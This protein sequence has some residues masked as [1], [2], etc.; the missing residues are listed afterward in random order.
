MD[1]VNVEQAEIAERAGACAVMALEKVP[2]D[3]RAAGGIARMADPD[4]I[5]RIADSVSIPVMAKCRIGHTVEARIIE[6]TDIDF[7]D[8]SE[9]LTVADCSSYID[10]RSFKI[11]FVSGCCDLK[12]ALLRI[13][14]GAAMIRT[15]GQAGTGNVSE[16]VRNLR[17]SQADIAAVQTFDA[18]QIKQYA[19]DLSVPVDLVRQVANDGRLPVVTFCAGGIATPA[20]AALLMNLGADGI[21]V[22]S[23]WFEW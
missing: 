4:A 14:E 17:T 8:E 9:V 18:I 13:N 1:V 22:G 5:R 21:F 15:K 2:Y 3:I 10:K 16:A 6:A 19:S 12:E 20:D 23:V 11:P 7:I